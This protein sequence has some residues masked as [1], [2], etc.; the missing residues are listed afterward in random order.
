MDRSNQY[1][2]VD[3]C[4]LVQDNLIMFYKCVKLILSSITAEQSIKLNI[5]LKEINK[6]F[7]WPQLSNKI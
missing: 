4:L 6:S 7:L 5:K 3:K 1:L 2:K